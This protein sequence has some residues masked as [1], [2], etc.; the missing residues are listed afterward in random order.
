MSVDLL[1]SGLRSN[2]GTTEGAKLVGDRI[3]T[4]L[5]HNDRLQH[6]VQFSQLFNN[7]MNSVSFRSFFLVS[8]NVS[9]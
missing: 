3:N 7:L 1:R 2:G 8:Q 6:A 4:W 5:M 9:F